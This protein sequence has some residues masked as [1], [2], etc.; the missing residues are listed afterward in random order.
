M[1]ASRWQRIA[2][3]YDLV[4]DLP[5]AERAPFLENACRGDQEL[6]G[7]IESLLSQNVSS[8]GPLERVAEDAERAYPEPRSIG[9]YRILR[10]IGEGAIGA[11]YESQRAHT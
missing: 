5:P 3:L 6:R 7:E 8:H 2:E 11:V 1:E 4:C 9:R 10:L